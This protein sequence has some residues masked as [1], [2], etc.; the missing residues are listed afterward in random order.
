MTFALVDHSHARAGCATDATLLGGSASHSRYNCAKEAFRPTLRRRQGNAEGC[1][2][3]GRA[4]IT[5][6]LSPIYHQVQHVDT[7]RFPFRQT[8]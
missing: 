4:E 8:P 6:D 5:L 2:G 7:E 1:A 3:V